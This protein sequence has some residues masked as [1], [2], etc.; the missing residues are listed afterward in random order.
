MEWQQSAWYIFSLPANAQCPLSARG[1]HL[2]GTVHLFEPTQ[3]NPV[4][5]KN[6]QLNF[7]IFLDHWANPPVTQRELCYAVILMVK[8]LCLRGPL[9]KCSLHQMSSKRALGRSY[10]RGLV[11]ILYS[12][13]NA[14]M[15]W[16]SMTWLLLDPNLTKELREHVIPLTWLVT[17][18]NSYCCIKT[19]LR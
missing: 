14:C 18:W 9:D 5:L 7:T 16:Y 17:N 11:K 12:S 4:D 3:L 6:Q 8:V 2:E 1:R 13:A 15:T 10:N 19:S